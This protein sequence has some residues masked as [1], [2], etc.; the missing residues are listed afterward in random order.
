MAFDNLGEQP[1]LFPPEAEAYARR[2]IELSRQR[3]AKCEVAFDVPYAG[4]DERKLDIYRPRSEAAG[5]LPVLVFAHGGGWTHGFKEWMGLLAPPITAIP[6]IF[7]SVSYRL[8]PEHRFPAQAEDCAAAIAW[9]SRNIARFGGDPARIS[10]GGHSAG[11]HL[12]ALVTVRHDLLRAAGLQPSVIKA[13]F[14]VSAR[15]NL[16]FANPEPGTSEYRINTLL[17]ASPADANAASPLHYVKS[18]VVP[19]YLAYG[20]RDFPNIIRSNEEMFEALRAQGG[21]VERLML[22]NHDHFDTALET[23]NLDHPWITMVREAL[24]AKS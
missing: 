19:F 17:L 16:V 2:A 3:A 7:V 10:V 5:P 9:V 15:F 20:T 22:S 8:A 23:G 11:G 4:D 24:S 14:P 21:K 12:Y 1:S 18:N 13:C 6:A